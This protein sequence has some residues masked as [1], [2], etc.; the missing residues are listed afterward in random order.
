MSVWDIYSKRGKNGSESCR[1]RLLRLRPVVRHALLNA[2]DAS[3]CG[4]G[5][6]LH[7]ATAVASLGRHDGK[8]WGAVAGQVYSRYAV[9]SG[10][11]LVPADG[12]FM[13]FASP[14][15]E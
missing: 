14:R 5:A 15:G 3:L 1:E 8:G 13:H 9:P 12:P 2:A 10:S 6:D 7:L 11:R 4:T